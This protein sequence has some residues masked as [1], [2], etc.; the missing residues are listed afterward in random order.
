MSNCTDASVIIVTPSSRRRMLAAGLS[1]LVADGVGSGRESQQRR[2][3]ATDLVDVEWAVPSSTADE[4]AQTGSQQAA[5]I[6]NNIADEVRWLSTW[7][8]LL[9]SPF[10]FFV[11]YP[12]MALFAGHCMYQPHVLQALR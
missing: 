3:L 6:F 11:P 1:T 2:R 10:V 5:A 9:C 7:Y 12:N 4:E 8:P